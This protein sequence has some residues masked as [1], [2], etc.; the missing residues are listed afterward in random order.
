VLR[1]R[2]L[3]AL[4]VELDGTVINSSP[5]Q[6]PWAVFAYLALAPGPVRR[7]ELAT[8][9]WPDVLDQSARASLR[10][11][12][13]TL[14]RQ[15]GDWLVVE[16]ER[17]GLSHGAGLW[18]DAREFAADSPNQALVLCRG[19]LLEGIE[20]DWALLARER[21]RERVIDLLERLALECEERADHRT[22]I[23]LTR[24]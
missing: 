10:S 16:G 7:A 9:F 19:E 23:D 15:L 22:A 24:R 17:V 12:L 14:R 1:A 18:I 2:L 8:R 21:H 13:W 11:A 6:R 3:G 20:D 4:E 5:S